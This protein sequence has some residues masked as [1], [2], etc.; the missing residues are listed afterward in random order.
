MVR[1]CSPA[2]RAVR[3]PR[4]R[5]GAGTD[6][7]SVVIPVY[8]GA[9]TIGSLVDALIAENPGHELQVVLVNDGSDDGSRQVCA[10]LTR[11]YPGVLLVDLARNAG[12]HNAV[13]AGLA[14]ATGAWCVVM[15]DDFQNPPREAFRLVAH[16][17][18]EGR[19]IV[20]GA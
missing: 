20:F 17:R 16:A 6:G 9:A 10:S 13:M 14:H 3:R 5:P 19:D 15:D 11:R 4:P 2:V 8:N 12:E 18:R 7:V 1:R